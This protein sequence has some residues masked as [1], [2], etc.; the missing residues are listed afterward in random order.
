[1]ELLNKDYTSTPVAH[2]WF[3]FIE[4][5]GEKFRV[6]GFV[7]GASREHNNNGGRFRSQKANAPVEIGGCRYADV[8]VCAQEL[9][10]NSSSIVR[11]INVEQKQCE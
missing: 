11:Y 9:I 1:M 4:H 10:C 5:S 8:C 2:C 6:S 3:Y 7:G